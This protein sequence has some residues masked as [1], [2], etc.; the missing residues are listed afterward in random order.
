MTAPAWIP[1]YGHLDGPI[2]CSIHDLEVCECD[3]APIDEWDVDPYVTGGVAGFES[4]V[5][6]DTMEVEDLAGLEVQHVP[7]AA[8]YVDIDRGP[9]VA[10]GLDCWGVERDAAQYD[11]PYPVIAHPPCGPWGNLRSFCGPELLAQ[12][13]L[14]ILAVDQ[15]R[16]WGGVLEHPATS[17]L[18]AHCGLPRPGELPDAWGGFSIR[19]DQWAFG[20][21]AVKPTLF[22]IV[23]APS[24]PPIPRPV[25]ERPAT[26]KAK[27]KGDKNRSMLE[28]MSKHERH[29]TPP[30][31]AAWL[32]T[33]A[34]SC[35]AP[36]KP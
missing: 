34:A 11:G 23:G 36:V 27:G 12:E 15:V 14:S 19:V 4:S 20:H 28:R 1:V 26:G 30:L 21:R 35:I 3:C 6:G 9:Y 2:W 31:L 17:K 25:G 5:W 8:L 22:Y 13:G 24:L 29:L 7:V 32:V 33:V 10:M 16:R 18:W